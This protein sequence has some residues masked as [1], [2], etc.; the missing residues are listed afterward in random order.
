M[1]PQTDLR[2][3]LQASPE[4]TAAVRGPL[5]DSGCDVVE[6]AAEALVD[7]LEHGATC[8]VLDPAALAALSPEARTRLGELRSR[9]PL[10]VAGCADAD[11]TATALDAGAAL[12]LREDAAAHEVRAVLRA[13]IKLST[14]AR[15]SREARED[16]RRQS[17]LVMKDDLTAAYNRRFF[18]RSL[19]EEIDR[20]RRFHSTVSLIFMDIDN[21]REVNQEHGHTMG[22]MVLREAAKRTIHTV[23]SIDR[24]V[25][26]GGDEFCVILPETD[27]RGALELAERIRRSL[28][29]KP[30]ALD[31]VELTLTASFGVAAYPEHASTKAELIKA[32]DE[33]M[34]AVKDERKNG[35]LVA[36][37]RVR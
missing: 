29:S 31:G 24:C 14:F 8:V 12:T 3:L 25:R 27:W 19:E 7:E 37:G 6:D 4:V 34:F 22:S 10:L 26:Y 17:A 15:E 11:Q 2:A 32:A 33:A 20:A 18:D 13:A 36:G 9:V 16:L 5:E 35:I 28:A 1:V 30:F 21:L 23:R